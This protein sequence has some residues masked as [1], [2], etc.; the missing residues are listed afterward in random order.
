MQISRF[1][2]NLPGAFSI[3]GGGEFWNLN[4]SIRRNGNMDLRMRTGDLNFLTSLAGDSA[5]FAVPDSMR[6]NA[7]LGVEGPRVTA[8]L[9]VH[10]QQGFL[11]LNADYNL[12]D[13]TYH[14]DLAIDSLQINHFLPNDSIY[15]LSAQLKAQGKGTDFT[16]PHTAT[17]LEA[18]LQKLQY[19]IGT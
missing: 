8:T 18:S 1:N 13:E 6:L 19:G 15:L 11:G 12:A 9:Q 4:D 14:A 5:T 10:E 7:K 3:D 17:A 2:I 16:S